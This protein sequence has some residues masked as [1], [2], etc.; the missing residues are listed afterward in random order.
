MALIS[1]ACQLTVGKR[2]AV[3][4]MC[5]VGNSD[6]SVKYLSTPSIRMPAL[7]VRRG[8]DA[9]SVGVG[10]QVCTIVDRLYRE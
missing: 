3:Q 9:M 10:R 7:Q 8:V 5:G 1:P 6:L 2:F 4:L